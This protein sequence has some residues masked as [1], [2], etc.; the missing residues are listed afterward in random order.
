VRGYNAD[1]TSNND[2]GKDGNI[3]GAALTRVVNPTRFDPKN[4]EYE[5]IALSWHSTD[6]NERDTRLA[7]EW[8]NF[9]ELACGF[10]I[11]DYDTWDEDGES[12][13]NYLALP[14]GGQT[15]EG[16]EDSDDFFIF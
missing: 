5:S 6:T 14:D 13:F 2:A 12:S 9:D 3:Q 7:V 15:C 11:N 16:F 10:A 8:A 1:A 4:H